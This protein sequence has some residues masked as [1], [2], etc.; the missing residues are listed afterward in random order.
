MKQGRNA[1]LLTLS[2]FAFISCRGGSSS[3]NPPGPDYASITVEGEGTTLYTETVNGH[4]SAGFSPWLSC[5]AGPWG[6]L[7]VTGQEWNGSAFDT[8]LS[9]HI[10]TYG[11]GAFSIEHDN[12]RLLFTP[13]SGRTYTGVAGTIT[14]T[15][16]DQNNPYTH[17][18]KGTFDVISSIDDGSSPTGTAHLTGSFSVT[19]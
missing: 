13:A 3:D 1:L 7:Y 2:L 5:S 19:Q 11:L 8:R 6:D 15:D 9:I 16:I 10:W 4:A 18:A 17:K 14:L 12:A